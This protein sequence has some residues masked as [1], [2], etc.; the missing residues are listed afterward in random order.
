MNERSA[1]T[2]D[3]TVGDAGEL[4]EHRAIEVAHVAPLDEH[5]ARRVVQLGRELSVPD[6]DGEHRT[7]AALEQHLGES[8]GRG[9]GVERDAAGGVD[10][11]RVERGD[12][13]VRRAAHVVVG[14]RDLERRRLG[15]LRV[16][17]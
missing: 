1:I 9:A 12:Q 15:D 3:G 10:G 16:P 5:E 17:A 11:E 14:C 13:L 7:G 4:G 8:A 2:S 6:V